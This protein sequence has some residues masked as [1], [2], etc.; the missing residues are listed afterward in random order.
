M[1]SG[2]CKVRP[3][4]KDYSFL[5]TFGALNFG[6]DGLPDSFSIYDGR[7][8]PNQDEQD[9][10]FTPA[11]RPLYEGCTA[12]STTFL[13]GLEDNA[14]Y[15]PDD[16]YFA[17]PPGTDGVGRDIRVALTTA[18]TRGFKL[19]NGLIGMKKGDYYNVYGA[20]KIDD[21]SAAKIALW[22]NQNEKRAVSVGTWWYWGGVPN[23][24]LVNQ[25]VLSVPSYNT[26]EASL[27]NW[28]IVGWEGDYLIGIPWI[29]MNYGNKG[30]VK[31][32]RAIYNKL[33]AQPWTAAYTLADTPSGGPVP[34]GVTA[35]I[36][37]LVYFIR[38]LFNV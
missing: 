3:D 38:H 14:L 5:H 8:I 29:G 6:T 23:N 15:P 19:P 12:E 36:D 26:A 34:V 2:L 9:T 13:A 32:S 17:T 33:M 4:R 24:I 11:I 20:D 25:G 27:H 37:H 10:R 21:Y 30:L 35:I 7:P 18:K 1:K 22:I 31:V 28:V 16:F